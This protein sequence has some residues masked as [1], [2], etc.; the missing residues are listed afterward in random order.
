MESLKQQHKTD[1]EEMKTKLEWYLSFAMQRICFWVYFLFL[2]MFPTA[3][4]KGGSVNNTMAMMTHLK[5]C[6]EP[7]DFNVK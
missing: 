1:V 2:Q 7:G 3:K 6:G 5:V 4:A